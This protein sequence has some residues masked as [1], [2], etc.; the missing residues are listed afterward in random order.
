M[1]KKS[2]VVGRGRRR[3]GITS[4]ERREV[5]WELRAGK[6]EGLNRCFF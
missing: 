1:Q 2:V 4:V 5:K 6:A 3:C